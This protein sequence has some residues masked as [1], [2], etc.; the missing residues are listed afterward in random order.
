MHTVLQWTAVYA[1]RKCRPLTFGTCT[2][3]LGFTVV[4]LRWKETWSNLHQVCAIRYSDL[5]VATVGNT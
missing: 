5:L 1:S 2:C 3:I 4:A